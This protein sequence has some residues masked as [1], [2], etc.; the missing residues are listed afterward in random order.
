VQGLSNRA[1]GRVSLL[2]CLL[3]PAGARAEMRIV[4]RD[5]PSGATVC[6]ID[7][8]PV[9]RRITEIPQIRFRP[10][11]RV[12]VD[13]GGCVKTGNIGLNWKRYVD[14]EALDPDRW[15]H[16]RIQ[17]PGATPGL[18]R[19][20][21]WMGRPLLVRPGA[22]EDQLFLR[23][24]YE[25][26]GTWYNNDYSDP[27]PG[28]DNQCVGLGP[29]W[30]ELRIE[31]GGAAPA[32]PTPAPFD[33]VWDEAERNGLPL[34]PRW[35][36]QLAGGSVP[37]PGALCDNFPYRDPNTPEM[38]VL[39]TPPACTTQSP[40]VDVGSSWNGLVCRFGGDPGRLKG[41]AD[42]GAATVRGTINWLHQS[43][44]PPFGDADYNWDLFPDNGGLLTTTNPQAIGLEFYAIE[45]IDGF[46]SPWWTAFRNSVRNEDGGAD[47]MADGKRAVV[48]GL[49]NLDCEHDCGSESHPVYAMAIE[50]RP[51]PVDDL[52]AIFARNWGNGGYCADGQQ[53]LDLP[54]N[55]L[56]LR[57]PWRPG[58]NAVR[59]D[60]Q[61]TVFE[62]H[63]DPAVV[64][65]KATPLPGEGVE[66]SFTLAE[67]EALS[68]VEGE[69]H[70]V[71]SESLAHTLPVPGWGLTVVAALLALGLALARR[72]AP[73][74]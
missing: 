74:G 25:D 1:L 50:S 52:W 61:R 10:G 71:W 19:I 49:V 24:G 67:P 26:D 54:R 72:S 5:E 37:D 73:A 39:F 4:C 65:W 43:T 64:S 30:V 41:H 40:W 70:L 7:E 68:F 27:D 17:I 2:V 21:G 14:P 31:H 8:P 56:V 15:F 45:S 48:T 6:R 46:R 47:S 69:L 29:A 35:A 16:G 36:H 62:V 38:G 59:V 34:N 60:T 9:D 23:L 28:T 3:A 33:L 32:E 18:V 55:T 12:T 44:L 66:V 11:D 51:E 63:G 57:L 42:W 22:D 53:Y 13:A 20:A 58:A